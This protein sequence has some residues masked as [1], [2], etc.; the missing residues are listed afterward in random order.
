MWINENDKRI[1]VLMI[2]TIL[3]RNLKV[4]DHFLHM[5]SRILFSVVV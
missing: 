5:K 3:R 1:D 2:K 4:R